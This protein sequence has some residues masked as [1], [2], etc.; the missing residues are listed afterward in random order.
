MH[1]FFDSWVHDEFCSA[2]TLLVAMLLSIKPRSLSRFAVDCGR[3]F[4]SLILI[5]PFYMIQ[6]AINKKEQMCRNQLTA[7]S[8][9]RC[10][11]R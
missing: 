11:L 8:L 6:I 5:L 7:V 9:S 1:P 2:P 3:I 10:C 4:L